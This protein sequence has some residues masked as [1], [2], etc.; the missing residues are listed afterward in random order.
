MCNYSYNNLFMP[1]NAIQYNT[2]KYSCLFSCIHLVEIWRRLINSI[3]LFSAVLQVLLVFSYYFNKRTPCIN[4][5]RLLWLYSF[6]RYKIAKRKLRGTLIPVV[7]IISWCY[8]AAVSQLVR[9]RERPIHWYTAHGYT[10]TLIR[11]Y[12]DT[13]IHWYTDTLIQDQSSVGEY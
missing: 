7:H 12:A 5:I 9:C 2:F 13:L 1:C 8:N 6:D 3:F 4:R 11:W 10:D